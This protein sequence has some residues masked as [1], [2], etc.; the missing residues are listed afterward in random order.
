MLLLW[1]CSARAM[2][3]DGLGGAA[4]ATVAADAISLLHRRYHAS[5]SLLHAP[6]PAAASPAQALLLRAAAATTD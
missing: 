6:P 1:L 3:I 5:L 2:P 4:V